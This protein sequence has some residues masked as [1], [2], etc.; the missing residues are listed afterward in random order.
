[1][2]EQTPKHKYK[3][4]KEYLGDGLMIFLAVMLGFIAESYREQL[5]DSVRQRLF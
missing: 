1:M 2:E 3:S 4:L 5:A